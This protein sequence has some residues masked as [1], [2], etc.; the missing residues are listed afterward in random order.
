MELGESVWL[1]EVLGVGRDKRKPSQTPKQVSDTPRF[2]LEKGPC[3]HCVEGGGWRGRGETGVRETHGKAAAVVQ[4]A[5][6]D[7]VYT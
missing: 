7:R 2:G 3:S 1:P 6:S 5:G 4:T